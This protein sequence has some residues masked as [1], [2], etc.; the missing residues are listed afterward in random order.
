MTETLL[1]VD[2]VSKRFGALTAVDG[3]S[4]TIARGEVLGLV[5]ES[6][7]GKSKLGRMVAGIVQASS[8]QV[9][10]K[11][12]DTTSLR[13]RRKLALQMIF[14][15]PFASLNPRLRVDE[16]VGEAPRIHGLASRTELSRPDSSAG[17]RLPRGPRAGGRSRKVPR[18]AGAR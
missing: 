1:E 3:V 11:G 10:F 9:R 18:Y 12:E 2:A 17:T 4:L 6:G 8:G 13:G 7:C 5:G 16:I 14:Q 15:N